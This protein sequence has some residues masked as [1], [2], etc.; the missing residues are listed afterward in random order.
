[1]FSFPNP[2]GFSCGPASAYPAVQGE[3]FFSWKSVDTILSEFFTIPCPLIYPWI[4]SPLFPFDTKKTIV[5]NEKKGTF[6][7]IEKIMMDSRLAF[8]APEHSEINLLRNSVDSYHMHISPV[9][10][11]VLC[12]PIAVTSPP[13][14]RLS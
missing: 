8:G 2:Q 1:M 13:R 4:R 7:G 14:V 11:R 3:C 5:R 10:G 12:R 9:S 6:G